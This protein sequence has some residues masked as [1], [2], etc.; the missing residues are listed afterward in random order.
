VT[1]VLRLQDASLE[2][3]ARLPVRPRPS[4]STV[5]RM[6]ILAV[7]NRYQQPGGE[8]EVFSAETQ[9]LERHGHAVHRYV[10]R[11][12][13]LEQ[14]NRVALA[15]ET[16]W[17]QRS[18]RAIQAL[19]RSTRPDIAHFHN[20]LPRISPAAYYAVTR[21]G[22]PVVQTVHNYRLVC[23]SGLMFRDGSPCHACVGRAVPLPGIVHGCYRGSRAATAAVAAMTGAHRLLAT[24]RR[25]VTLYVALTEFA[26][27]RLIEGGIADDQIVVKP[28]FVDPDPGPGSGN[29][30]YALFVGRL[31]PEKGIRTLLEAWRT[32]HAEFPLRIVGDGPLAG[33]V[34]E[35][36]RTMPNVV[37][38]GRRTPAE[39]ATLLG[40]AAL[41]I[42]PSDCYETFGRVVIEAF[43]AGTPVV[44]SAHG[45]LAELV[46]D[47]QN[48]R[49][50]RAGDASA[51]VAVARELVSDLAIR[52]MRTAARS[53]FEAR[54]GAEAN[55]GM[56]M[57]VYHS[58]IERISRDREPAG[59]Q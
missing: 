20:T 29:G 5:G 31:S 42:C 1:K 7:H 56:L 18:Y 25:R 28:N 41:L 22:V 3:V 38:M 37:W 54:Y 53:T 57:D 36:A 55:Y 16:I 34:A 27:A 9:L 12:D 26:R 49:L 50:F 13:G 51:L 14:E 30:G 33:E 35:A 17:S 4:Q 52:S 46:E 45:A 43:A 19:V 2:R 47:G 8:D 23:P 32:L 44:A 11:N 48:G 10:V 59:A 40:D 58:A 6:R 24:W 15:R 39:V 21:E